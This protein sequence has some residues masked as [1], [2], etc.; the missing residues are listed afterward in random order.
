MSNI[1]AA[2]AAA[3]AE[4]ATA[5]KTTPLPKANTA[6]IQQQGASD[7]ISSTES[8]LLLQPPRAHTCPK[9]PMLPLPSQNPT[10]AAGTFADGPS[11][12]YRSKDTPDRSLQ[13]KPFPRDSSTNSAASICPNN[14]SVVVGGGSG[15]SS[16]SSTT[17]PLLS[18]LKSIHI[19]VRFS[20][21]PCYSP[22]SSASSTSSSPGT[23]FLLR[24]LLL[25]ITSKHWTPILEHRV[26]GRMSLQHA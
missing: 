7:R 26:H 8:N 16:S 1:I 13:P 11:P 4:P 25:L 22:S 21:D 19:P 10:T 14:I 18:N 3:A 15:S 24:P 17:A 20:M 23:P 9:S 12:D 2:V 5:A 6:I